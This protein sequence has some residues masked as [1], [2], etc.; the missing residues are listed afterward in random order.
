MTN[1][2]IELIAKKHRRDDFDCGDAELNEY[3]R[4]Y[5]RQNTRSGVSRTFVA[6]PLGC[7][8]VVGFYSLVV[9]S[10]DLKALPDPKRL[11]RFPVPVVHLARLA[12]DRA[13]QKQ[14]LGGALLFDAFARS[15]EIADQAGVY[16][17]TV[18]AKNPTTASFY[19]HH[20]FES[21][22]DNDLHLHLP[23]ATIRALLQK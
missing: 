8:H 17:L 23:I 7:E 14:G 5:A 10:I 20:G 15:A 11:P 3:L 19:K 22:T 6:C 2:T 12:V 9:G 1:W 13:H 4:R 16:T 21:L 18:D